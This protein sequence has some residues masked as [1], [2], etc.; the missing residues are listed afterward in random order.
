MKMK[1]YQLLLWF[2]IVSL[3]T[4]DHSNRIVTLMSTLSNW[5]ELSKLSS[6]DSI[7]PGCAETLA[8]MAE[9]VWRVEW[10]AKSEYS[11]HCYNLLNSGCA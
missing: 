5:N 1:L 4:S 2:R 7:S 10:V 11:C 8:F 9:N 3:A 6:M